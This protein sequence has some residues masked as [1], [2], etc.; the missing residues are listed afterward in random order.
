VG[1]CAGQKAPLQRKKRGKVR[2]TLFRWLDSSS[3]E[4]LRRPKSPL[5]KGKNTFWA[6]KKGK[7]TVS[8]KKNGI[9]T[10]STKKKGKSTS[11]SADFD[12]FRPVWAFLSA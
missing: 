9:S 8:T 5:E 2:V 4:P 7:N 10:F 1:L 6:K 3:C 12:L 11:R